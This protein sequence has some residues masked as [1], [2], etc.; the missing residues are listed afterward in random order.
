MH[1]STPGSI[2]DDAEHVDRKFQ[3]YSPMD[4]AHAA[5]AHFHEA[6]SVDHAAGGKQTPEGR[7]HMRA[8]LAHNRLAAGAVAKSESKT[9]VWERA[10]TQAQKQGKGQNHAYIAKIARCMAKGLRHEVTL[11]KASR[12]T[13]DCCGAEI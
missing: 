6:Y 1:A 11:S 4:H 10:Q 12:P 9:G 13:C 3:H 5:S 2:K 8:A 7:R